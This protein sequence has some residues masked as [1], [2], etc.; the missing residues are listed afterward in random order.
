[1]TIVERDS[2]LAYLSENVPALART[3]RP[4]PEEE[5]ERLRER[6]RLLA[7]ARSEHRPVA[8]ATGAGGL[9]IPL[10]FFGAGPSRKD[11]VRD[12]IVHA[13][14]VRRIGRLVER[15][16]RDSLR[17]AEAVRKES[18][19]GPADRPKVPNATQ[20]APPIQPPRS[21][22]PLLAPALYID[23]SPI[24]FLNRNPES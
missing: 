18:Q 5:D 13:D 21:P 6:A 9:S 22:M 14:N 4:L 2:I 12:S 15:A 7:V 3:R 1:M 17:R 23:Q 19:N 24:A 20:Q 8:T 16:R 10:P 11:R